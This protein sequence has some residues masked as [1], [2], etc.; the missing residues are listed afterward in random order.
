MPLG[1]AKR[2]FQLSS[3]GVLSYSTQPNNVTR[4][5]V[6]ILI[7]TVSLNPQQNMIHIDTGTMIWH[8]RTLNKEDYNMWTSALSDPARKHHATEAAAE[9]PTSLNDTQYLH[10]RIAEGVKT[11]NILSGHITQFIDNITGVLS[12]MTSK[13]V[14]DPA[15]WSKLA[16]QVRQQMENDKEALLG[17]ANDNNEQWSSVQRLVTEGHETEVPSQ[18]HRD[19]PNGINPR[20]RSLAHPVS[21]SARVSTYS[22]DQFYDAEEILMLSSDDED[23]APADTDRLSEGSDN[24]DDDDDDDAKRMPPLPGKLNRQRSSDLSEA[25]LDG[26]RRKT[27]PSPCVGDAASMISVFRKN[28]GKDLSQIAMPVSMNEPLSILQRACEE[29]EYSEL[30]DKAASLPDSL[31]RLM[32]VSAF[33]VSSY[34]SS[35]YRTGRKPFNPMLGETYEN[36]RPDKGFRFIAEKVCHRPLMIAAYAESKSFKYWQCSKLK[37]KFWGKSMEFINEGT[38]HIALTPNDD[39]FTFTKPSSWMRNM[40]AGEKY[41]E[42]VGEIKVENHTTGE[43]AII[44]FKEGTGGGLFGTPTKRNGVTILVYDQQGHQQ[45]RIIGKWSEALAETADE[46][47]QH[48]SVLWR[49]R[50]P[51]VENYQAYYGLTRFGV[52]LNE[53]TNFEKDKLPCTDTRLRPDQRLLE[54]GQMDAADQEKQR[55]EQK[56]RDKRKELES[57][58]MSIQP[59]WFELREDKFENPDLLMELGIRG[60]SWQYT[61]QYWPTRDSQE[62]PDDLP[63]L[64]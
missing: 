27:L 60:Q 4:G 38:F 29:L 62:W 34:A 6:Q 54:Q 16:T 33:I 23:Y 14:D 36:I 49:A 58:G 15:A 30:L 25:D 3:T 10:T 19:P 41:L 12:E 51:N 40:L 44:S 53:I 26:D 37:S 1:W 42:H 64:W 46:D 50:P 21:P 17:Y 57:K 56:Q 61:G 59:Q 22:T 11:A 24:D 32:Y 55:I 43:Y 39:H 47:N 5:A 9:E 35:Q 13:A 20:V 45:R 2:W 8:L 31:E 7:A 48:L 63:D 18:P 52:E 28:V